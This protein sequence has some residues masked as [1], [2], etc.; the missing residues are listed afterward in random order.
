MVLEI[1]PW[2]YNGQEFC[3]DF[4]YEFQALIKSMNLQILQK[5]QKL[6]F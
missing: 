2:T 3:V 1:A 4:T 6:F 5:A